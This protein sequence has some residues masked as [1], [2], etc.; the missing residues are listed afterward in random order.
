M[1]STTAAI[2]PPPPEAFTVTAP[3]PPVGEIVT[4]VP[5]TICVTPPDGIVGLF[6]MTANPD[7]AFQ[8]D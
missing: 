5:A 4:F 7:E 2:P 6:N 3:V 8:S 1:S